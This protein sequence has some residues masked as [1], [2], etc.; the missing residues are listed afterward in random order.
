MMQTN[1]QRFAQWRTEI[2]DEIERKKGELS[3]WY[4]TLAVAE[5]AHALA[6]AELRD[7]AAALERLSE[8]EQRTRHPPYKGISA[9]LSGRVNRLRP[10]PTDDKGVSTAQGKIKELRNTLADL[11]KAIG[12]LAAIELAEIPAAKLA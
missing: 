6:L 7:A 5:K 11:E 12:E 4:E 9:A 3:V 2:E 1:I 10:A 8:H